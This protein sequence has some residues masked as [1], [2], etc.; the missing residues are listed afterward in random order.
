M[1]DLLSQV[2]KWTD[3]AEKAKHEKVIADFMDEIGKDLRKM[4]EIEDIIEPQKVNKQKNAID[5]FLES[6]HLHKVEAA[7]N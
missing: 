7:R 1:E 5:G 2:S 6:M 4:H 3:Q